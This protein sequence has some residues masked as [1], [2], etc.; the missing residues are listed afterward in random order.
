MKQIV[1]ILNY[2]EFGLSCQ[3]VYGLNVFEANAVSTNVEDD[4]RIIFLRSISEQIKCSALAG[5]LSLKDLVDNPVEMFGEPG[6]QI[7]YQRVSIGL[8]A[9]QFYD[10][11]RWPTEDACFFPE[12]NS[13]FWEAKTDDGQS[14][15]RE[16]LQHDALALFVDDNSDRTKILQALSMPFSGEA[17]LLQQM[18][19]HCSLIITSGGDAMS[20]HMYSRDTKNF[21]AIN[22]PLSQMVEL[23]QNSTWYLK[24]KDDLTWDSNEAMCLVIPS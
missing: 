8:Y 7:A 23:I 17:D 13:K 4:P 3:S 14:N 15:I 12:V 21:N 24:N 20:F 19:Q 18:S 2:E 9:G 16:V 22:E 11:A 1:Q 10:L 6:Q 5:Y